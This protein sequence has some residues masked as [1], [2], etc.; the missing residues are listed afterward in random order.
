MKE[1]NV[2]KIARNKM[3]IHELKEKEIVN[4]S[5]NGVI[6]KRKRVPKKDENVIN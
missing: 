6:T 1:M 5:A 4:P 3:S 2:G